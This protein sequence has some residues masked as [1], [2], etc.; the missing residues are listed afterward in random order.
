MSPHRT[1]RFRPDSRAGDLPED[2]HLTREQFNRMQQEQSL[3]LIRNT[4]PDSP[5]YIAVFATRG[6]G[7]RWVSRLPGGKYAAQIKTRDFKFCQGGFVYP[8]AAQQAALRAARRHYGFD[9]KS[10][11][12]A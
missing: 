12:S 6:D 4:D 5:D 9:Q 8:I 10:V 7:F 3:E 2:Q 1:A 11:K